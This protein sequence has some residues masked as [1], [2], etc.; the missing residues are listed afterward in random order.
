MQLHRPNGQEP[1][2]V[3]DVVS[4]RQEEDPDHPLHTVGSPDSSQYDRDGETVGTGACLSTPESAELSDVDLAMA[5]HH[6]PPLGDRSSSARTGALAAGN[7]SYGLGALRR[8]SGAGRGS[9]RSARESPEVSP[10]R[11][12]DIGGTCLILAASCPSLFCH[13]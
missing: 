13:S 4:E 9:A 10:A 12:P 5:G 1:S 8:A 3:P 11:W 2:E 6:R 7:D